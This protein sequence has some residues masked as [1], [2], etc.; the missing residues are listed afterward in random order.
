MLAS[1]LRASTASFPS[2]TA[3]NKRP[4]LNSHGH[5]VI[6]TY[7]LM[8]LPFKDNDSQT[9][10]AYQ[11]A[12]KPL[13]FYEYL[14]TSQWANRRI[15]DFPG[16]CSKK[17]KGKMPFFPFVHW[18]FYCFKFTLAHDNE[19]KAVIKVWVCV[20]GLWKITTIQIP[21]G[22]TWDQARHWSSEDK[23]EDCCPKDHLAQKGRR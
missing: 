10:K 3:G 12:K 15:P 16:E 1:V 13:S 23:M 21:E 4:R 6:R 8:G 14:R 20:L 19:I 11:M 7:L 22:I 2:L 18:K 17:G 5:R 9:L